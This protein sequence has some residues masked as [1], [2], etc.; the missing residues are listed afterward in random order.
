L[1]KV[2]IEAVSGHARSGFDNHFTNTR[3]YAYLCKGQ[4]KSFKN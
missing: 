3:V 2:D 4:Q 1:V